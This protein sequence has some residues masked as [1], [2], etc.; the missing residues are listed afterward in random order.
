MEIKFKYYFEKADGS[1]LTQLYTLL[2][3]ESHTHYRGIAGDPSHREPFTGLYDKND[4]PIYKGDI[5]LLER[6]SSFDEDAEDE[7]RVVAFKEGC[8]ILKAHNDTYYC[9]IN[10]IDISLTSTIGNI[11]QNPELLETL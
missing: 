5:L 9:N 1:Y 8:F 3:L 6:F 11:H 10:M 4:V 7:V 2:Q